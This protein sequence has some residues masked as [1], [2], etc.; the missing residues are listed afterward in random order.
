MLNYNHELHDYN[1]YYSSHKVI[2]DLFFQF[3]KT[4]NWEIFFPKFNLINIY[5]RFIG[6]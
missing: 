5:K 2:N 1:S 4:N 3:D 6:L